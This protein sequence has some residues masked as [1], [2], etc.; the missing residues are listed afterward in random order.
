MG[1]PLLASTTLGPMAR[2]DLREV[3]YAQVQK[4]IAQGATLLKGGYIP[5]CAGFYYP[6]TVLTNVAPGM[7]AF[8]EELFGP[9]ICITPVNSEEE[10]ITFANHSAY[11]LG[12]AIFTQDLQKGETLAQERLEAGSCFVNTRVSS[13]PR[14][15][16]GGIKH[17][18]IGREL[19]KE[20]IC[21]FVNIK[22]VVIG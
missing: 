4:S 8:D 17:S 12:A 2:E 16:F 22:T 19:S 7:P 21:E 18:G 6:A 11:G 10:G 14:L 3:L 9:V 13:D 20:G 5:S 1:D 15:P